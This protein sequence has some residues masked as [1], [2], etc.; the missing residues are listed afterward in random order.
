M[1][2]GGIFLPLLL[3]ASAAGE[4]APPPDVDPFANLYLPPVTPVEPET[5]PGRGALVTPGTAEFVTSRPGATRGRLGA[6]FE[7]RTDYSF[8]PD[9]SG[10]VWGGYEELH[11]TGELRLSSVAVLELDWQLRNLRG[12]DR[13]PV[14]ADQGEPPPVLVGYRDLVQDVWRGGL[15]LDL[16]RTAVRLGRQQIEWGQGWL[17]SPTN[18]FSRRNI[19]DPG[20]EPEGTDAARVETFLSGCWEFEAVVGLEEDEELI[21]GASV[22]YGREDGSLACGF[23]L[24]R[25]EYRRRTVAGGEF[26]YKSTLAGFACYLDAALFLD[27]GDPAGPARYGACDLGAEKILPGGWHLLL[28]YYH[29]GHGKAEPAS[30]SD[31]DYFALVTGERQVIGRNYLV[32]MLE[33]RTLTSAFRVYTVSNL[34]DGGT[35]IAPEYRWEPLPAVSLVVGAVI[36][37]GPP[38][39]EFRPPAWKNPGD[40]LGRDLLYLRLRAGF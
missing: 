20:D 25:D 34:N 17:F 21:A 6:L 32:V 26:A 10:G 37:E 39:S 1:S 22:R 4:P 9:G 2:A 30:Y 5:F 3:A 14:F 33:K 27:T 36:V 35:V 13:E 23:S 31:L 40:I 7:H 15:F 29:D 28:E 38:G 24:G 11:L 8:H 16:D 19:Y 12:T 18:I